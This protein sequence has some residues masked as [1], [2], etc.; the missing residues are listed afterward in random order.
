MRK[1]VKRK[2]CNRSEVISE[3]Q[4][5]E[6]TETEKGPWKAELLDALAKMPPQKF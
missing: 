1:E 5:Y 6:D 3:E 4:V 2:I